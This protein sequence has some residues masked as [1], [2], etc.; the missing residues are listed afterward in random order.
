MAKQTPIQLRINR[1]TGVNRHLHGGK[2]RANRKRDSYN[3]FRRKSNGGNG[4]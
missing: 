3:A 4:G 1:Q 2:G